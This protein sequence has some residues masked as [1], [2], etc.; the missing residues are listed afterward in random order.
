M[1][2]IFFSDNTKRKSELL[3]KLK[4][5]E[6]IKRVKH[7]SFPSIDIPENNSQNVIMVK[8]GIYSS[9]IRRCQIL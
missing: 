5:K 4:K 1:N 7:D 8:I 3:D 2:K 9:C 6:Q